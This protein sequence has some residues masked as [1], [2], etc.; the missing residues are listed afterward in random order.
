MESNLNVLTEKAGQGNV[1]AMFELGICYYRGT[2]GVQEHY[3]K[4]MGWFEKVAE[5]GTDKELTVQSCNILV[6]Y[7]L[8]GDVVVAEKWAKRASE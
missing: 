2:N 6:S 1:Q 8:K 7:Y 5:D 3:V 4:A